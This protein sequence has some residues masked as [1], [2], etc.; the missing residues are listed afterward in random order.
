M[1]NVKNITHFKILYIFFVILS[2]NIFFFSTDKVD[3]K[4]FDI[5]NINISRPFE[6]NFNK[7][8][9]INEG[10]KKAFVELLS[11]IIKSSDLKKVKKIEL[12]KIK[13]MIESFTIKEEKFI[14][15]IYFVNL[16]VSFNKKKIFKYL[17]EKN[18][19]PSAPIKKKFLFI[20]I[21]IDEKKRDLL[22]FSNNKIFSEWGYD[23]KKY[24][25]IEYIL[26]TEDLEDINI[27]KDKYEFIEQ[28]DFKEITDKYNL[29]NS[30][31]ALIFKDKEKLRVLSRITNKTEVLLK[32]QSF[33]NFN[34]EDTA[35]ANIIVDTLKLIYEDYWKNINQI[36]TSLKLN[37]DIKINNLNYSKISNF[38]E[39][40]N[41]NDLIY[42]YYIS[43]FDKDFTEYKVIFNG[44]PN[45]F[46]K[47]MSDNNYNFETQNRVWILK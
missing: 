35:Q 38:E 43:K 6:I 4:S 14:N 32:N 24:H 13:G 28:Y 20:P 3:A 40:L 16:G 1:G 12:S 42:N 9:V 30:I 39:I 44:T 21:I 29:E 19:F 37:L 36:N 17:E 8:E 2:L 10:F 31:V 26:P 41:N 46:L 11:S 25:L 5:N 27:I 18:I 22:I 45:A 34:I 23:V 15:E 33:S 7:N 47:K